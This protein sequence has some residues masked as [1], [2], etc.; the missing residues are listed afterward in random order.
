MSQQATDRPRTMRAAKYYGANDVRLEEV[1]VP[2][3]GDGE[4]LLR[5]LRSGICGTDATEWR[6]GP[7]MLPVAHEHPV[8]HHLGAVIPGHEF[9]GEVVEAGTSRFA[10]G[11]I[12]A[13]GAG[14]SCGNCER[15]KEGRGNLC[16][17]YWTLGLDTDG[18][19]TEYVATP[20]STL[21]AL[22]AGLE[23]D[24]A[25]L[26][27]PLAV[28]LHAARRSG[29]ANGD[30]V[31]IIGAGAIGTFTLAGLLSLVEA[32]VTVVDLPSPK[33]DRALRLGA[34]AT[35]VADDIASIPPGVDVVIEASGAPGQINRA[36]GLVRDGGV[37]LQVGLPA[38]AQEIDVHQL[39]LR[40]IT[41]Q[42]TL[43]H[44]GNSDMEDAIDILSS[45]NLGAELL[46]SVHT[47]EELPQELDR[48]AR[49]QVDGKVIFDL[50]R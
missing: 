41:L 47:L 42:T 32:D 19:L 36:L 35:V 7:H 39:V 11:D 34:S 5:V 29:A 25:A 9:I 50:T 15:C 45:T 27:Q 2:V 33:L 12:V 24:Q 8:T 4:V 31:V 46:D 18:G 44:V 38:T 28:G 40:E 10:V 49:G 30:R 17:Q 3:P 14:V 26:A 20:A 13:S 16:E 6:S 1:E 37:V 21:V 23:L 22:P 48:L 43:A